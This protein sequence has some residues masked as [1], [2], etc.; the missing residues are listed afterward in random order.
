MS[1]FAESTRRDYCGPAAYPPLPH[2]LL[3]NRGDGRFEDVSVA[4]GV[5]AAPAPGLGSIAVD[6]DADGRTTS[7]WPT[8]AS[9]TSSGA[10]AATA[11]SQTR[12]RSPESRSRARGSPAPGW[13]STRAT[14]TA[15]ATRTSSSPTSPARRTRSTWRSATASTPTAP[16]RQASPRRACRGR[17]FGTAFVDA[18]LD[19]WLDLLVVNGA[20]RLAHGSAPRR[21]RRGGALPRRRPRRRGRWRHEPDGPAR[22]P[23]GHLRA[24]GQPGQLYRNLGGGRFASDA[25]RRRAAGRARGGARARGR[26]RR[27]RRRRGRGGGGQRRRGAPAA[28]GS[29]TD[30]AG[31]VSRWVGAGPCPGVGRRAVARA[32]GPRRARGGAG[33]RRG[34]SRGPASQAAPRRQLRFRARPAGGGRARQGERRGSSPWSGGGGDD[35]APAA[36]RPLP[37]LVRRS[38]MSSIR[39]SRSLHAARALALRPGRRPAA[40]RAGRRRR[41]ATGSDPAE[42]PSP[43]L[44]GLEPAVAAR[45]ARRGPPRWVSSRARAPRRRSRRAR[46]ATSDA[47]STPTVSSTRRPSVTGAP[48][49]SPRG[50]ALAVPARARRA[51]ARRPRRGA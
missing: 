34:P 13:G 33:L 24:L 45:S 7:G 26:G 43:D 14:P 4:S 31:R 36:R 6:F 18:D 12:R 2:R 37:A 42:L 23:R 21:R 17:G 46:W 9:P 51:R 19:G 1:C 38:V 15:T 8:T 27:R 29:A 16:P 49:P 25:P 20:V 39:C 35:L 48:T 22:R 5:A 41:R 11:R 47:S 30:R 32:P 40:L 50:A 28:R 3:R 44:A 10:T